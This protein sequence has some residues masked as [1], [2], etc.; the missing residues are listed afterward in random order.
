MGHAVPF[1]FSTDYRPAPGVARL[2]V[3]TPP[4][5]SL[6][7]LECGVLAVAEIGVDRLRK[8]S[9]ALTELFLDLVDRQC[10]GFDLEVA[11]PRDPAR[12]G[13][14]VSLHHPDGY[15]IMQALIAAGVVGDF[16]APD[17]LRFGFAPAYVRF[18]DVWDAVAALHEVLEGGGWDRPEHRQ[19]RKVT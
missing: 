14:Q 9:M 6:A 10:G 11:S 4:I 8:K 16:R 13:S 15:A 1:D 5:L 12:R 7:A 2:L 3:G 19:R 17:L 18:V